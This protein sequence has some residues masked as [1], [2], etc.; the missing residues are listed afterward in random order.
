MASLLSE[1]DQTR[2]FSR[3]EDD[4]EIITASIGT[5][6]EK[7]EEKSKVFEIDVSEIN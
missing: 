4:D 3:V 7:A 5:S 2:L 6:K 1:K